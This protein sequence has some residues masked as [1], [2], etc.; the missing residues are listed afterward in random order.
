MRSRPTAAF[1]AWAL[2]PGTAAFPQATNPILTGI[3]AN[4]A[5]D[6]GA[7]TSDPLCGVPIQV[8][9]YSRFTYDSWR[10]QL[11]LFGGGHASTPRTDVD[12]FDFATLQWSSAY[13]PTPVSALTFANYD[14]VLVRWISSGHPLARHTYDQLVF[15]PSTG[16]LVMLARGHGGAYCTG[17]WGWEWGRVAHYDP[18]AR[19]WSWSQTADNFYD[20]S[21]PYPAAEYDPVSGQIVVVARSGLWTYDPVSRVKTQ[22]LAYSKDMGYANNLVHFPPN[23]KMYYIARGAP[24]RVWEVTLDRANWAAST[25]VELAPSGIVFDSQESGWAYDSW[26]RVIG[27]GVRNGIFYA[28]DPLAAAWSSAVMQ[29]QGTGGPIGDLASHTLDFDPV[30]GVFL[31]LTDYDSGSRTWAY[32][33]RSARIFADGFE[34]G[35]T[36]AWSRVVP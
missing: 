33:Y 10:H 24:T 16:Q 21:D 2:L 34:S 5:R 7:Y 1:V 25:V 26:T 11:L 32:R 8:T 22:R 36:S 19:T 15:A 12:V 28:F 6:L 20:G 18:A 29:I 31:F 17:D 14:P 30:D 4:T 35:D 23:Q 9:D 3:P 27:G 13:P